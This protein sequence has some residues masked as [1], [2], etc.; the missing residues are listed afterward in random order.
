MNQ[1][2]QPVP[3]LEGAALLDTLRSPAELKQLSAQDLPRVCAA[4]RGFLL[5][6]VQRTGGHLG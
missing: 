1:P 3:A 2:Q 4:L 6:S 5:E